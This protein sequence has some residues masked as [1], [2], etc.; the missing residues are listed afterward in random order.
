MKAITQY[1][2]GGP[3]TLQLEDIDKP[4]PKEDEVLIEVKAASV[5]VADWHMMTGTPYM[6]RLMGGGFRHPKTPRTGKDVAGIVA[7]VGSDVTE[8]QLGDEV[9]G[10]I[11]GS[12]AEFAVA[13]ERFLAAKPSNMTFAEAAAVP[14]AG[15][16]ALQGLRDHGAV[17]AGQKVLVNGASGAVGTWT[18][19]I[20]KAVGAEV[21]AVCST[22]NVDA[23][24][25]MGADHV[26]DYTKNDFTRI[27]TR[28]DVIIDIVGNRSLTAC[29]RL[30]ID[31]GRYV[32]VGGP[33]H[34][35]MGP[36]RRM[37][38]AQLLF[39]G[40]SQKFVWF[41]ANVNAEDLEHLRDLAEQGRIAAVIDR[42]YELSDVPRAFEYLAAGHAHGKL[43]I[44]V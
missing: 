35:W 9:F 17:E 8:F 21:T 20:A 15:F 40:R 2:F 10:E 29:R 37:L 36:M 7:A 18:V 28:F 27:E 13:P 34:R 4:V 33:K 43:V 30:L 24:R 16:T 42:S 19:Q 41:V 23:A 26:I 5:N 39:L 22:G 25:Q 14:L 31:G 12:F 1:R 11:D 3:E 44:T 32:M 6:V 38:A